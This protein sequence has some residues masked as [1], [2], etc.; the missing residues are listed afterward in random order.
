MKL[1]DEE[2]VTIKEL[3]VSGKTYKELAAQFNVT[4]GRIYQIVNYDHNYE[5]KS[6]KPK[7]GD[8]KLQSYGCFEI[9]SNS[10]LNEYEVVI[11]ETL[12]CKVRV[13]AKDTIDAY[14]EV[15]TKY[16]NG[17]IVLDDP[18][19]KG[20]VIDKAICLKSNNSK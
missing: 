17:E 12:S 6:N 3:K 20:V 11:T 5:R 7:G 4:H 8:S 14:N 10:K 18:D 9:K 19:F 2:I 16:N 13:F 15:V 1:T